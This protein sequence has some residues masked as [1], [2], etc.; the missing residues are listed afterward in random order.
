MYP[1]QSVRFGKKMLF[2][3]Y[4]KLWFKKLLQKTQ[5]NTGLDG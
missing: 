3:F 1:L 5:N 4:L 2:E